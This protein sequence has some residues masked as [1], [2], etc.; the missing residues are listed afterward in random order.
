MKF[1]LKIKNNLLHTKFILITIILQVRL[2]KT[3]FVTDISDGELRVMHTK[4]TK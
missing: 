3:Q 2:T 1:E 4:Y